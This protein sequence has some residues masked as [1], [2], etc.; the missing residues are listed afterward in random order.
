M[1]N[2]VFKVRIKRQNAGDNNKKAGLNE[3]REIR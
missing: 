1:R 2:A 3:L